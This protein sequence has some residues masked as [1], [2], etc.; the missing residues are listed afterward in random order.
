MTA[1]TL[2][3]VSVSR[4]TGCKAKPAKGCWENK[5]S[6]PI[7][8]VNMENTQNTVVLA[9]TLVTSGQILLAVSMV[10]LRHA[11]AASRYFLAGVLLVLGILIARPIVDA[12]A[13]AW[14]LVSLLLMLPALLSLGPLLWLYIASLTSEQPWRWQQRYLRHFVLAIIGAGCVLLTA[15]L[16]DEIRVPLLTTG[17]ANMTAY[18]GALMIAVFAL[19]MGWTLQ[20]GYYLVRIIKRLRGYRRLLKQHFANNENREL[21]WLTVLIA[22]I[23]LAWV[24]AAMSVVN[25]NLE[26]TE[27][28]GREG[29]AWLAL[30]MVWLLSVW[31]LSQRPGFEGRY[32]AQQ[33]VIPVVSEKETAGKYQRSALGDEQSQRIAAKT[34]K[35]MQ[36]EKLFLDPDISLTR[37]ARAIGVTPNYL[38]QTLNETLGQTFFDYINRWRIEAAKPL[39]VA[40]EQSVLEVALSVGFNARSSFYKA[41]KL[42]TG[43]TPGE[44]RQQALA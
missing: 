28:L 36:E 31:G 33:A 35:A 2:A 41:F 43:M 3:G 23:A 13:P 34:E 17:E 16:P 42:H 5:C 1:K 20:S 39:I 38:S 6:E 27:V 25:D 8:D 14:S 7:D 40:N 19:V 26:L 24:L 11:G 18:V 22:S 15:L 9:I 44:Y 10:F 21:H 12:Y 32:P 37:L 30:L 29:G 4:R